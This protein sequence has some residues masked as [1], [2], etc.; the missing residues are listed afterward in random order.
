MMN[1][2]IAKNFGFRKYIPAGIMAVAMAISANSALA[3]EIKIM[4]ISD[5]YV[6][7]EGELDREKNGAAVTLLVTNSDI[8]I[9]NESEWLLSTGDEVSYYGEFTLA[10]DKKY[11]FKFSL[12]EPGVYNVYLASKSEGIEKS[13]IIYTNEELSKGIISDALNA[14]EADALKAVL[15]NKLSELGVFGFSESDFDDNSAKLLFLSLSDKESITI[16]E[17]IELTEKAILLSK[18]NNGTL[19]SFYDYPDAEF[20]NDGIFRHCTEELTKAVIQR[21]AKEKTEDLYGFDLLLKKSTIVELANTKDGAGALKDAL[22]EYKGE[23]NIDKEITTDL[24][25]FLIK[26]P[27]FSDFDDVADAIK[28]YKKQINNNTGG[29]GGGGGGGG[30]AVVNSLVPQIPTVTNDDKESQKPAEIN[31]FED[32]EN[33]AW[34]HDAITRLYKDKVIN[35]KEEGKFFPQDNVTRAEFAK[36]LMLAFDVK[37]VDSE[38]PFT[39]VSENDWSYPYI[40]SAY[41]AGITKGTDSTTFGKDKNITRQ[42]LCVMVYRLL[43]TAKPELKEAETVLDFNDADAI[44]DYAKE[45]VKFMK[46]NSII[47]GDENKNF[48]PNNFATRAESVKIIYNAML[49]YENN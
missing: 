23:L 28:K 26:S 2:H 12:E 30:N 31:V 33:V 45:A 49:F 14:E 40:R 37:L 11:S 13:R 10:A 16:D 36:I 20:I 47:S 48:N 15:E 38:I 25:D 18:I 1:K 32:I 8:D 22:N 6:T 4:D 29:G 34:A 27:E 44:A 19:Q 41:L 43:L 3:E 21:M 9:T 42:D 35:G 7:I 39:D 17:M 5:G 24:C 46:K